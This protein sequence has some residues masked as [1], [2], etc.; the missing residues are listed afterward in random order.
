MIRPTPPGS[1][2]RIEEEIARR[3]VRPAFKTGS[4]V[5]AVERR[6]D[7]AGILAGFNL[8]QAIAPVTT[9]DVD[10]RRQSNQVPSQSTAD[11]LHLLRRELDQTVRARMLIARRRSSM[12]PSARSSSSAE[13]SK[14]PTRG[15]LAASG[16]D[17][18]WPRQAPIASVMRNLFR[19]SARRLIRRIRS[20]TTKA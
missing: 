8:L 12:C 19:P 10:R 11:R 1:L 15:V 4:L 7:G 20:I 17:R 2:R 9:G 16:T 5:E 6:L 14:A 13:I 18:C 3:I